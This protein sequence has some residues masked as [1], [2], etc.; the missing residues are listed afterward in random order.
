MRATARTTPT[1]SCTRTG[2]GWDDAG[3]L[4]VMNVPILGVSITFNRSQI[5]GVSVFDFAAATVRGRTTPRSSTWLRTPGSGRTS[6]CSHRSSRLSPRSSGRFSRAQG[7][8]SPPLRRSRSEAA[9]PS[10]RHAT[11]CKAQLAGRR[12]SG[13]ARGAA[14]SGPEKRQRQ[15]PRRHCHRQLQRRGACN[16]QS[17]FSS[18]LM[19]CSNG[20]R[21]GVGYFTQARYQSTR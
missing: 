5:G 11:R 14:A 6:S 13:P 4:K 17:D 2:T 18:R 15:A 10:R 12:S 20:A 8:R 3:Q 19:P 21:T 1:S 7:T 16:E 9:R